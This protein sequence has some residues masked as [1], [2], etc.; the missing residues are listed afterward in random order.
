MDTNLGVEMRA[1]VGNPE[2]RQVLTSWADKSLS[3]HPT[4]DRI[5]NRS[6]H[7]DKKC[8]RQLRL[9]VIQV[10]A[11]ARHGTDNTRVRNRRAMIAKDASAQNS[12]NRQ[13]QQML[14]PGHERDGDRNHDGK[15]SP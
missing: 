14:V 5:A 11:R 3:Q 6:D 7:T 2:F 1:P 9:D 15:R 8:I 10:I 13:R 12:S 4:R